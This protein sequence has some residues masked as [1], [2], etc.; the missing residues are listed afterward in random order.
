MVVGLKPK[1]ISCGVS[2]DA[3][4]RCHWSSALD[5]G[6]IGVVERFRDT[7]S[8]KILA[9]L[10][11][12]QLFDV[13]SSESNSSLWRLGYPHSYLGCNKVVV[14]DDVG[15]SKGSD[16]QNT[17]GMPCVDRNMINLV[18]RFT[19][20][21]PPSPLVDIEMR[22]PCACYCDVS[23]RSKINQPESVARR[24]VVQA[25]FTNCSTKDVLLSYLGVKIVLG[26]F[27]PFLSCRT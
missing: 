3:W 2:D 27:R 20:R 16:I 6:G 4:Q 10:H 13:V 11:L 22:K 17:G 23:P 5:A 7:R 12:L 21:K 25:M 15:C 18:D 19:I 9:G 1:H 8:A 24:D 14:R 26:D